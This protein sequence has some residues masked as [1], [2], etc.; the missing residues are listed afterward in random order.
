MP[1]SFS[2]RGQGVVTRPGLW[3][4]IGGVVGGTAL[5]AFSLLPFQLAGLLLARFGRDGLALRVPLLFH[6]GVLALIG[7]LV[8]VRGCPVTDRRPVLFAGNHISWLD[9]PVIGS[10]LPVSFIAKSEVRDWPVFG[11]LARLQRTVFV[12]RRA[13]RTRHHRDE[14][15]RRLDGGGA[16]VLFA[17][18]TSGDGLRLL[19]YKSAFF[20]VAEP[21]GNGAVPVQPFTLEYT[22]IGGY[23]ATRRHMPLVAWIGDMTLGAHILGVLANRPITA[24][25]TF[26][27]PVYWPQFSGRKELAGYCHACT[28]SAFRQPAAQADS[29]LDS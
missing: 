25:L 26:H 8:E 1:L 9:I 24:R 10:V 6:R 22:R 18:G 21:R 16:L 29:L 15:Q 27:E 20:S 17:E 2:M 12:E 28:G 14:M 13:V 11:L 7:V 23:P 19:P 3:L 4:R 5:L